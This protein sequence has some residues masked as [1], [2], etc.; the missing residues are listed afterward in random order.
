MKQ[1]VKPATKSIL[2]KLDNLLKV[3]SS[4]ELKSLVLLNFWRTLE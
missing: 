1:V 3:Y 2:G 4:Q